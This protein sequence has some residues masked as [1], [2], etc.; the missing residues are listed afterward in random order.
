[1]TVMADSPR[2]RAAPR[3]RPR[4]LA[5]L[6]PGAASVGI[7]LC[8]SGGAAYAFLALASHE[9]S[10][11]QYAPL[12]TFWSLTFLVGP[13]SFG[14]LERETGR[15][16]AIGLVDAPERRRPLKDI[17]LFG[18]L[19]AVLF[20][21]GLGLGRHEISARLFDGAGW[22]VLAAA[23][24]VPA[25]GWEFLTF[26]ILA[27]NRSFRA[28]GIVTGM[29]GVGRLAGGTV[30][31][32]VGVT[33]ATDFGFVIAMAPAVAAA[34]GVRALRRAERDG[35]PVEATRGVATMLWLLG[36]ALIQAFL[37]NSGPLLVKL[38][39]P[40]SDAVQTGRFL[41]GLVLVRVPLFLYSAAAATL[42]PALAGA[43]ARQDWKSF[44]AQL[45]RLALFMVA[46]AAASGIF[47]ATV[48]PSVLKLVFGPTYGLDRATLCAL[49][50][51]TSLLLVAATFSIALTSTGAVRYL[52]GCCMTGLAA[53]FVPILVLHGLFLRVEIG[54]IAGS[55]ACA[56]AMTAGLYGRR[57][58]VQGRLGS[59]AG[60]PIFGLTETGIE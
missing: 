58:P 19:E 56:L 45:D 5:L 40:D 46:L 28:Y 22:L 50:G 43:A 1:M 26:G 57:T 15:R 24:A 11:R 10:A 47:S 51:A 25:I 21:V 20:A 41:S 30:L 33:T 8:V 9:L 4:L 36:A 12:A 53:T 52:F 44:R 6:P 38:L 37:V 7:G 32:L 54:L 31:V 42:L 60:M 2:T 17:Y 49:S 18:T 16:I 35:A 3:L 13:G 59:A 48:G 34:C 14:I 55:A 23:L 27:G 29:E 39:A